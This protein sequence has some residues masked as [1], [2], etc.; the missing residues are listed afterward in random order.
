MCK[1]EIYLNSQGPLVSI[2]IPTY[3]RSEMLPRAIES[4]LNQTY[5]NIQVIVVDDNDPDTEFRIATEQRMLLYNY[6]PRVKYIRHE[7]I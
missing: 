4:V 5:K 1:S 7:K 3:K 6:N 2:I